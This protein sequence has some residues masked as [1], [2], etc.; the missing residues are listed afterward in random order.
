MALIV[1]N[2]NSVPGEC[3]PPRG[4]ADRLSSKR[5]SLGGTR[6]PTGNP[7][8]QSDRG[9]GIRIHGCVVVRGRRRRG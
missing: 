2:F 1:D 3:L 4:R 7:P 6:H 9:T 5:G 8:E